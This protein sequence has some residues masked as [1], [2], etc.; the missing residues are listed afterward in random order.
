MTIYRRHDSHVRDMTK[1]KNCQKQVPYTHIRSNLFAID[2]HA[3][4][5]IHQCTHE[6]GATLST[7][8]SKHNTP[9]SPRCMRSAV[10]HPLAAPAGVCACWSRGRNL[11]KKNRGAAVTRYC[12]RTIQDEEGGRL[13]FLSLL[14]LSPQR[15]RHRLQTAQMSHGSESTAG[16]KC[17]SHDFTVRYHSSLLTS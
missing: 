5:M 10:R 13:L 4:I 2:I 9:R 17:R 8:C 6:L 16:C 12:A 11:E 3:C 1:L 14:R 7:S 15:R